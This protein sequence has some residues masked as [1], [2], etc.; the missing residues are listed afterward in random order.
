MKEHL[1]LIFPTIKHK[2]LALMYRQEFIDSKE[3][4]INGSGGLINYSDYESWL[5][6]IQNNKTVN[7]IDRVTSDTYF[8]FVNEKIVGTIQ[9]RHKLNDELFKTIGHIGFGV[10]PSKRRQGYATKMLALALDKCREIGIDKVLIT[11]NKENQNS[12]KTIIKN[13]GILENEVLDDNNNIIQ[14]YWI[15]L[16]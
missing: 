4:I 15:T 5:I 16:M 6:K 13:G 12:A 3:T 11:C 9:I 2:E 10:A 14:R 7:Q 1:Q 8:A